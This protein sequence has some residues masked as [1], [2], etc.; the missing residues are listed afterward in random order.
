MNLWRM[1]Q[2]L[3]ISWDGSQVEAA[4]VVRQQ[5]QHIKTCLAQMPKVVVV[6]GATHSHWVH[7]QSDGIVRNIN[8]N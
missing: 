2:T 8:K 3:T 4:R 6:S 1:P 7:H 5:Q